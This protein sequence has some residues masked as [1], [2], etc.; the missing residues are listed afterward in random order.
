MENHS[1]ILEGPETI[2]LITLACCENEP[3]SFLV[4]PDKR[5]LSVKIDS[6]AEVNR[7]G[8]EKRY[9]IKATTLD[10]KKVEMFYNL[11]EKAGLYYYQDPISEN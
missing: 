5:E 3:I 11:P 4:A 1:T 2:D 9:F 7:P 10:Q 8:V 6:W